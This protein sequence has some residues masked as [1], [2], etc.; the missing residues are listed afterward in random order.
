MPAQGGFGEPARRRRFENAA[1]HP[2]MS[3]DHEHA[4]PAGGARAVNEIVERY[5]RLGLGHAVQVEPR[6]DG[7]LTALQP[8]G[9]SPVD[10]GETVERR[11][12][13]RLRDYGGLLY[14]RR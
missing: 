13:R 12:G 14:R 7:A 4:T 11:L 8:L 10:A 2:A 5:V 9:I 1:T 6:L 3:G